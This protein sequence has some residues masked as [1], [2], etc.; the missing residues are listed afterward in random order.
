M[1]TAKRQSEY[2]LAGA[3]AAQSVL[4]ELFG[5]LGEF[6]DKIAVVGGMVPYLL[7]AGAEE[8]HL[9]TLDIDLALDFRRISD[10]SYTTLR[11]ALESKGYQQNEEQPFR[12]SRI[13]RRET[14]KEIEVEVDLLA[15]EYGGSGPKRRTQQVQDVRARK[16][17]GADLVFDNYIELTLKGRLPGGAL[18]AQQI[19]VAGI[20]PFFVMKGMALA[21][22]HKEKDSYDVYYCIRNCPDGREAL[23]DRFMPFLENKLVREGLGKIRSV[24]LSIEHRGPSDVAVML[25][26]G[27]AEGQE[28]LRRDAFERTKAFLDLLKIEPW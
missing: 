22:R 3:E 2:T 21:S 17:R 5:A 23:A 12:F 18:T 16:A 13:V 10:E 1:E 14:G 7:F 25:S 15:P 26:G 6:R 8:K 4:L 11:K 19:R 9:G 27:N 20:V 28:V 24:F